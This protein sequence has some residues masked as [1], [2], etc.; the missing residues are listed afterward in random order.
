MMKATK[1]I[2]ERRKHSIT[3]CTTDAQK[4]N[5]TVNIHPMEIRQ[6]IQVGLW[7]KL[8]GYIIKETVIQM[9]PDFLGNPFLQFLQ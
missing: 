1:L 3:P 5:L 6:L 9:K 7:T 4:L 2:I 8:L